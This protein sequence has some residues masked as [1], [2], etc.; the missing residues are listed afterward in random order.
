MRAAEDMSGGAAWAEGNLAR[1]LANFLSGELETAANGRWL[2][3]HQDIQGLLRDIAANLHALAERPEGATAEDFTRGR[4]ALG[5]A[6][7]MEQRLTGRHPP[8]SE[9]IQ[10]ALAVYGRALESLKES[11]DIEAA[12]G[13]AS[14]GAA[15]LSAGSD[16]E[17]HDI[18]TLS[19]ALHDD[20]AQLSR[21]R[22]YVELSGRIAGLEEER[23]MQREGSAMRANLDTIIAELGRAAAR[24]AAGGGLADEA[25]V[26]QEEED[27]RGRVLVDDNTRRMVEDY[28]A[29]NQMSLEDAIHTIA[30]QQ[31]EARAGVLLTAGEKML[32][33]LGGLRGSA[34]SEAAEIFGF[35][36][37]AA[38]EGRIDDAGL[39]MQAARS[40]A[41]LENDT[42]REAILRVCRE[43][44]GSFV[45]EYAGP[46]LDGGT[47]ERMLRVQQ[48]RASYLGAVTDRELRRN[49]TA[50][51][52]LALMAAEGIDAA[53]A[54]FVLHLAVSYARAAALPER[55]LGAVLREERGEV[56]AL[57]EQQLGDYSEFSGRRDTTVASGRILNLG[58]EES[59]LSESDI[60]GPVAVALVTQRPVKEAIGEAEALAKS[61][62]LAEADIAAL[63]IGRLV[64]LEGRL[65]AF[66][67]AADLFA[68]EERLAEARGTDERRSERRYGS[69]SERL[70]REAERARAAGDSELAEWFAMQ[71]G[72]IDRGS[73]TGMLDS[74]REIFISGQ[75]MLGAAVE[76]GREAARADAAG[77]SEEALR[78]RMEAFEMERQGARLIDAAD[79][80][81]AALSDFDRSV[82]RITTR[83]REDGR[84]ELSVSARTYI[85]IGESRDV[86]LLGNP[87]AAPVEAGAE[88]VA[89]SLTEER[90]ATLTQNARSAQQ[91]GSQAVRQQAAIQ[92]TRGQLM[93]QAEAGLHRANL[94]NARRL[95][96]P[97]IMMLPEAE[98]QEHTERLDAAYSSGN[99]AA[100][101]ELYMELAGE[102]FPDTGIPATDS[103]GRATYDI[104]A[105]EQSYQRV[106]RLAWSESFG[107]AG[108]ELGEGVTAMQTSFEATQSALRDIQLVGVG[109]A[110]RY[111]R[112]VA[113]AQAAQLAGQRD[114]ALGGAMSG[115]IGAAEQT[116][117]Q[118]LAALVINY[119]TDPAERRRLLE[120]LCQ[121]G[122]QGEAGEEAR[123]QLLEELDAIEVHDPLSGA[124]TTIRDMLT[125]GELAYYHIDTYVSGPNGFNDIIDM[126][127]R[128]ELENASVLLG[129]LQTE[130]A[131]AY[132]A[133][134]LDSRALG[135]A[136][137][138]GIR[139]QDGGGRLVEY[140]G[141][142]P[143]PEDSIEVT[144]GLLWVRTYS[145]GIWEE[146][147]E[148]APPEESSRH[149][150]QRMRRARALLPVLE[151]LSDSMGRSAA[152]HYEAA[153]SYRA[154]RDGI[155]NG[156]APLEL[157]PA[158]AAD[159]L[160]GLDNAA[161]EGMLPSGV[162]TLRYRRMVAGIEAATDPAEKA[163]R[164]Q[165]FF[166]A[167]GRDPQALGAALDGIDA[168]PQGVQLL[169]PFTNTALA[170]LTGMEQE[171]LATEHDGQRQVAWT[172]SRTCLRNMQVQLR[173]GDD[174]ETYRYETSQQTR[175]EAEV[176]GW[177]A[178]TSTS[179]YHRELGGRR[180]ALALTILDEENDRRARDIVYNG[181]TVATHQYSFEP[182]GISAGTVHIQVAQELMTLNYLET[183]EIQSYVEADISDISTQALGYMAARLSRLDLAQ[184]GLA[185][186]VTTDENRRLI[187][188][189]SPVMVAEVRHDA[190]G[191]VMTDESGNPI[192]DMVPL[193]RASPEVR[194]E[195]YQ[196]LGM[197]QEQSM[198]L[199]D[200]LLGAFFAH[201]TS[202][203]ENPQYNLMS[204]MNSRTESLDQAL[205]CLFRWA[206]AT[207]EQRPEELRGFD[208]LYNVSVPITAESGYRDTDADTNATLSDLRMWQ[209][210]RRI[211]GI[212]GTMVE[213]GVGVVLAAPTGG[214]SL[215]ITGAHMGAEGIIGGIEMYRQQGEMTW[216][217][218]FQIVTGALGI[219]LPIGTMASGM[220]AVAMPVAAMEAGEALGTGAARTGA[221]Y[222]LIGQ[223]GMAPEMYTTGQRFG[224][225]FLGAPEAGILDRAVQFGG[226]MLMLS[227]GGMFIAQSVPGLAAAIQSDETRWWD[228]AELALGGFQN[229]ALPA[230]QARAN[231]LYVSQRYASG[232]AVTRSLTR[233]IVEAM[234]IGTPM[235]T[236]FGFGVARA[237]YEAN[238]SFTELSRADPAFAD[239][240][241]SFIA[242]SGIAFTPRQEAEVLAIYRDAHAENPSI[243]F[244]EFAAGEG[245]G[246]ARFRQICNESALEAVMTG[247]ASFSDLD[248]SQRA[249]IE[250]RYGFEN[251]NSP[252]AI[253]AA[254]RAASE[255]GM[256]AAGREVEAAAAAWSAQ[257]PAA[258]RM[259]PAG[260]IE[261][262]LTAA[263]EADAQA[264]AARRTQEQAALSRRLD[265]QFTARE[266]TDYIMGRGESA[267]RYS[268]EHFQGAADIIY[269]AEEILRLPE[270]DARTAALEALPENVRTQVRDLVLDR[271]FVEAARSGN[272]RTKLMLGLER[273]AYLPEIA[274]RPEVM[275]AGYATEAQLLAQRREIGP[276]RL[277]DYAAQRR[278]D[279]TRIRTEAQEA[280]RHAE[281]LLARPDRTPEQRGR[282]E[283]AIAAARARLAMA[284]ALD[285]SA[286]ILEHAATARREGAAAPA[287]PQEAIE[288]PVTPQIIT[289]RLSERLRSVGVELTPETSHQL[290]GDIGDLRAGIITLNQF[291]E[292]LGRIMGGRPEALPATLRMDRPIPSFEEFGLV[293]QSPEALRFFVEVTAE[294][295]P[296][297]F[298]PPETAGL[299][300]TASVNVGFVSFDLRRQNFLNSLARGISRVTGD[301]NVYEYFTRV[302]RDAPAEVNRRLAAEGL[303]ATV[304]SAAFGTSSDES[305]FLIMARDE[306]A[307]GRAREILDEVLNE[308]FRFEGS[309]LD[310]VT[311][312]T[313]IRPYI[314]EI[315]ATRGRV[316]TGGA[317]VEL[318][319]A[320]FR[321]MAGERGGVEGFIDFMRR[322]AD[323]HIEAEDW[324]RQEAG[325]PTTA[326]L[327]ETSLH[328]MSDAVL[329]RPYIE[330][331][332]R[333][334]ER[335]RTNQDYMD[336]VFDNP[337]VRENDSVVVIEG[338]LTITDRSS[339]AY[340]TLASL[341]AKK[342]KMYGATTEGRVGLSVSNLPSQA[343]GEEFLFV[344]REAAR[345]AADRFA[346]EHGISPE[347][348]E[349]R[350]TGA[351]PDFVFVVRGRR[352]EAADVQELLGY[353]RETGQELLSGE[354]GVS[355]SGVLLTGERINFS[356]YRAAM[357]Y[358]KD[359][360]AFG[361]MS[362]GP[363]GRYVPVEEIPADY[364]ARAM[365][366]DG[367]GNILGLFLSSESISSSDTAMAQ[368]LARLAGESFVADF[369]AFM[370][371]EH[372]SIRNW[373][374]LRV[375]LEGFPGGEGIIRTLS[376]DD[377][378]LFVE[379]QYPDAT[380]QRAAAAIRRAE[381]ERRGENFERPFEEEFPVAPQEEVAAMAVGAEEMAAPAETAPH[382]VPEAQV[383]PLE[384]PRSV[385]AR[386]AYE[387]GPRPEGA[388]RLRGRDAPRPNDFIGMAPNDEALSGRGV[389]YAGPF[390]LQE[391]TRVAEFTV[392][393]GEGEPPIQIRIAE[394][395]DATLARL[396]I[397]RK[398]YFLQ[399]L[400]MAIRS[401]GRGPGGGGASGPG[402]EGAP[403]AAGEPHAAPHIEITP[404]PE[405]QPAEAPVSSQLRAAADEVMEAR[406]AAGNEALVSR[407]A[408][409]AEVSWAAR[410]GAGRQPET[411]LEKLL[412][413]AADSAA[414]AARARGGEVQ[415][416]EVT[417]FHAIEQISIGAGQLMHEVMAGRL[418]QE[419]RRKYEFGMA[420]AASQGRTQPTLEDFMFGFALANEAGPV[421]GSYIQAAMERASPAGAFRDIEGYALTAL[422]L[423]DRM[424]NPVTAL[425]SSGFQS[426]IVKSALNE[427]FG[428]A[429]SLHV[430]GVHDPLALFINPDAAGHPKNAGLLDLFPPTSGEDSFFD[431]SDAAG[432]FASILAKIPSG[433]LPITRQVGARQFE[434]AISAPE[435][436]QAVFA[437]TLADIRRLPDSLSRRS[438]L[439]NL[440]EPFS[441]TDSL[442]RGLGEV[443]INDQGQVSAPRITDRRTPLLAYGLASPTNRM[444]AEYLGSR[445]AL[446][447]LDP[448]ANFRAAV[449]LAQTVE[450]V[451]WAV[452]HPEQAGAVGRSERMRAWLDVVEGMLQ[453]LPASESEGMLGSVMPQ[454]VRVMRHFRNGRLSAEQLGEVC[455]LLSGAQSV[456]EFRS[457]FGQWYNRTFFSDLQ[458]SDAF[459]ADNVDVL[460]DFGGY[461]E[462]LERF[463][464]GGERPAANH[465]IFAGN[466][467]YAA[468]NPYAARNRPEAY[469][470]VIGVLEEAMRARAAGPEAFARFKFSEEFHSE[471]QGTYSRPLQLDADYT[472]QGGV[473]SG[474]A[475]GEAIFQVWRQEHTGH[476]FSAGGRTYQLSESGS[477][478]AGFYSARIRGEQSCQDPTNP[479]PHVV[480]AGLTGTVELP[481]VKTIAVRLPDLPDTVFRRTLVLVQGENGPILLVQP[482]YHQPDL[483]GLDAMNAEVLG[484]LRGIYEPLGVEVRDVSKASIREGG[485]VTGFSTFSSGRSPFFYLDSDMWHFV[486]GPHQM[487]Q[488]GL[489]TRRSGE[490][491]GFPAEWS[492]RIDLEA[493]YRR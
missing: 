193:D 467:R 265:V 47:A 349:I 317:F 88:A 343:S 327:P 22:D 367:A 428:L 229:L 45:E 11:G 271:E 281:G 473:E 395:D 326:E 235:D 340:A 231:M 474:T 277:L 296:Q 352:L 21:V 439:S 387:V 99:V 26:S 266:G 468:V 399:Q 214:A 451:T 238:R 209:T 375:A 312:G 278:E 374:D 206:G 52:D 445:A 492:G 415:T 245:A 187:M 220:R 18:E 431:L 184:I 358:L 211:V 176:Y 55:T 390:R 338:G 159:L 344:N 146:F 106:R 141:E 307:R 283:E 119:V 348:I 432:S 23:D 200:I 116:D 224:Q 33:V 198:R 63:G 157:N 185:T 416:R 57:A 129:A 493:A 309:A 201:D 490:A 140:S 79:H 102:D 156:E 362:A 354:F 230:I 379:R 87:V 173:M 299:S 472:R 289:P 433:E 130:V 400:D 481:W 346:A 73:V 249:Y 252:E 203:G 113:E 384:A 188:T 132:V 228:Y 427:V 174:A 460:L 125:S 316:G 212:A 164:A 303:D 286:L 104:T 162:Q 84:L 407:E 160:T 436:I 61:I 111:G 48:E 58:T 85:A 147:D 491:V 120:R 421:F 320:D 242:R 388:E 328:F 394:A 411:A 5:I 14:L 363:E 237:Q 334:G 470:E 471:L 331:S 150:E 378:L 75:E 301:V 43:Y 178:P 190:N 41:G 244:H 455:Q 306:R 152:E 441:W 96:E 449:D 270:G 308:S 204:R 403:V 377:F 158:L 117:P 458:L 226:S 480:V 350:Q 465:E 295:L 66:E 290:E 36:I 34:R 7:D 165:E 337:Q 341:G 444:L 476:E 195:Y 29:R 89:A 167:I 321:Q 28:A 485:D 359:G 182:L 484:Y 98:R 227:G 223:P 91:S 392:T 170:H 329:E 260:E 396:G 364:T 122:M 269:R 51:F 217:A 262:R 253:A 345:S 437:Y 191:N 365:R 335:Y 4:A 138:V 2:G 1:T 330:E 166:L 234:T 20:P 461:R 430:A 381:A 118:V 38:I 246:S 219:L 142:G 121:P 199:N 221:L 213:A 323:S 40:Y 424:R 310:Y 305:G 210:G 483:P 205:S 298:A 97:L 426:W 288:E 94:E 380:Q 149:L 423:A 123:R 12:L 264:A 110:A 434:A 107:A 386:P 114:V 259:P 405:A 404:R 425:T 448:N 216:S 293:L 447:K 112:G 370:Q 463:T 49:A 255:A 131:S 3:E 60:T 135:Q 109:N 30:T 297:V 261:A 126:V 243:S 418:P 42:D 240:Y 382:G 53:D 443:L 263:E 285:N 95:I 108:R 409:D 254:D 371:R 475:Q 163:R 215:F 294:A 80:A 456:S 284:D 192:T 287:V 175:R 168:L 402:G 81:V 67:S 351:G 464:S 332:G 183:M 46:V 420:R 368:Q 342:G 208:A 189:L 70:L 101:Q 78:L 59:R 197:L 454:L 489:H 353:Y 194:A 319:V 410:Y 100:L 479:N 172:L 196:R 336:S 422:S 32:E 438:Y 311:R 347:T 154:A 393:R 446:K 419:F 318:S 361:D 453:R 302:V 15:Y 10:G 398:E 8:A 457:L 39:F 391:G 275:A 486:A 339:E 124:T 72:L 35:A 180:A 44:N 401:P 435:A 37:S 232:G 267:I 247:R 417:A 450:E 273:A 239:N 372:I 280:L 274:M 134:E 16:E 145:G 151:A 452:N 25:W 429:A 105:V 186:E 77:N 466:P 136:Y 56:M 412:F 440:A 17:R 202:W 442:S 177:V 143:R 459:V 389:R 90:I 414:A 366:L 258:P 477:F 304:T 383:V 128:G 248:P 68:F 369:R 357:R 250:T 482:E 161:A 153:A 282:I 408:V 93:D 257:Q 373:E 406:R 103:Q 115:Y 272:S 276:E 385:E 256:A 325:V 171:A 322:M 50:Y 64:E 292:R 54:E 76:R 268:R 356:D 24:I 69:E 144:D 148:T 82:Q 333:M 376:G 462:N 236:P 127:E 469:D 324:V 179:A 6:S 86:D 218:G 300:E 225:F 478:E 13:E 62:P 413:H 355:A 314:E 360:A 83:Q 27:L 155:L 74:A 487:G 133:Q 139:M 315:F 397:S 31:A 137:V 9:S 71:A 233:Q 279:A 251:P 207:P 291:W 241:H 65:T 169:T 92:R 488:N 313:A 19:L 181:E 222:R